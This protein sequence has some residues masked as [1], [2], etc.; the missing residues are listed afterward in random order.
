[1]VDE[2]RRDIHAWPLGAVST[3]ELYDIFVG[4]RIE[5]TCDWVLNQSWFHHWTGP[6]FPDGR[7]KILWINGP[8]GFGR[9]II[10]AGVI[11][12][13]SLKLEEDPVAYFFF[14]SDFEGRKDPFFAIRLWLSQL[15][16][17]P[18]VFEL[19]RDRWSGRPEQKATR[20][21]VLK[22]FRE[23]VTAIPQY[24]FILDG[25]DECGWTGV[26]S[27][28][29]SDKLVAC[30]LE[31]LRRAVSATSS[32]ILIVSCDEPEIRSA[33]SGQPDAENVSVNQYKIRP[34]D[35][36]SNVEVFSPSV[37]DKKLIVQADGG[38]R[39][40]CPFAGRAV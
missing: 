18:V 33:L 17:Y 24:T 7:A 37:V 38:S 31:E 39:G 22:L 36:Q 2:I 25:L 8:A 26:S 13:M 34:E 10:C 20:G 14:S 29:A 28:V 40:Y 11:E 27:S 35:V 30:F 5:G 16:P 12:D 15:V 21:D 23:V 19:F 6:D 32:Q 9:S 4:K 3:N 1:M